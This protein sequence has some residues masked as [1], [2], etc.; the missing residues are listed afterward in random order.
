[1]IARKPSRCNRIAMATYRIKKGHY[2]RIQMK[3][4]PRCRSVA[5]FKIWRQISK[6]IS[7]HAKEYSFNTKKKIQFVRRSKIPRFFNS[8]IQLNSTQF[9]N[10]S[11]LSIF[12]STSFTLR[13]SFA[14]NKITFT[15]RDA[16][17]CTLWFSYHMLHSPDLFQRTSNKRHFHGNKQR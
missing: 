15:S 4:D 5:R 17:V 2:V 9:T 11:W 7:E 1:M 6:R 8:P 16:R 12:K 10:N 13:L 14:R 3:S